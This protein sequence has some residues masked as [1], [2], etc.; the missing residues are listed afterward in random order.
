[1]GLKTKTIGEYTVS[2]AGFLASI[3]L[4]MA[5]AEIEAMKPDMD[6]PALRQAAIT[7]PFVAACVTPYI[8]WDDF[9]QMRDDVIMP[10]AAAVMELNAHWFENPDPKN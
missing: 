6:D 1:M 2:E 7:W 8:S 9:L 10:I 4:S 3:R 5:R